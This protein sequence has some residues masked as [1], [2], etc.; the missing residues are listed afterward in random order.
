MSNIITFEEM[1]SNYEGEWL[2]IRTVAVSEDLQ[3]LTGEVLAHSP[4]QEDIYRALESLQ[5][6]PL[7]I[8]Y[9]GKVPDDLAFIL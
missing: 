1:Q 7:A 5:E 3:V 8:E 9:M 2:L 4:V 6:Q